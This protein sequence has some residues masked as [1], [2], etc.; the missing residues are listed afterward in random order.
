MNLSYSTLE[1]LHTCPRKFELE[2]LAAP[3]GEEGES[4][5][6]LA[7]S[8]L[9]AGIQ[10]AFQDVPIERCIWEAYKCWVIERGVS[11]YE[12]SAKKSLCKVSMHIQKFQ[13]IR[14][15]VF[16]DWRLAELNE[17]PAVEIGFKIHLPKGDTYRGWID[18]VL[19]HK[20]T[21]EYAALELKTTGMKDVNP[22][23][24]ENSFQGMS[25]A[26]IVDKITGKRNPRQIFYV[27]EFDKGASLEQRIFEFWRS[28]TDKQSWLP[29]L[30]L[31]ALAIRTYNKVNHFPM[32]G[33]SCFQY[34]R[35]CHHMRL[36][37]LARPGNYDLESKPEREGLYDFEFS[38]EELQKDMEQV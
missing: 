31:D 28:Q 36:C 35:P 18:L 4:L 6:L 11:Y 21:D 33:S 32:R 15:E 30:A 19:Q 20:E 12:E 22:A 5:D 17:R 8:A 7:G 9:H 13:A 37:N 26:C 38:L 25:Y 3:E 14:N 23:V 34:W 16:G 1:L 24:Y 29:S 10:A 27:F 2:K